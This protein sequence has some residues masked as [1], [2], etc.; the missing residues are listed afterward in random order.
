MFTL[1]TSAKENFVLFMKDIG[2]ITILLLYSIC[3]S[4]DWNI[5]HSKQ[6]HPDYNKW[7]KYKSVGLGVWRV[8]QEY[9]RA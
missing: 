4:S 9:E 2:V 6:G 8:H 1:L 7:I 5:H 3:R